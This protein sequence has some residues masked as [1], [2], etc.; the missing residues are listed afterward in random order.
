MDE[1]G[2]FQYGHSKDDP[3]LPQIKTMLA[4]LDPLGMPV[5]TQVVSG[6][7]AD[8]GLYIPL[9]ERVRQTL[10]VMGLLWVGDCKMSAQ[11]TRAHIHQHQHYYLTPL[12]R[13]GNVPE[14]SE[15]WITEAHSS[16]APVLEVSVSEPDG[17]LRVI[18]TG[19]ER[20]RLESVTQSDGTK[21]EWTERL[22]LIHSPVYEQ[23]P[24][25]SPRATVA[26]CHCQVAASHP[27]HWTG[28]ATDSVARSSP[29]EGYSDS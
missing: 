14:L 7:T 28:Q 3:S 24:T 13:V 8:D 9:F 2:L 26:N 17:H 23:Q 19:Y 29:A 4:D 5:A 11:A 18:A 16:N 27:T 21:I 6:E 15:Q 25:S 10:Q 20:T 1:V 12:A 22:L